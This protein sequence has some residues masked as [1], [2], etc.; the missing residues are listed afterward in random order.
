MSASLTDIRERELRSAR[1]TNYAAR[2]AYY[3]RVLPFWRALFGF[4]RLELQLE[5][6]LSVGARFWIDRPVAIWMEKER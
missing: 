4:T 5:F 3:L 6:R 2:L 1:A